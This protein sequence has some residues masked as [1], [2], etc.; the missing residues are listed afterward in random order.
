MHK[1]TKK[2]VIC[3]GTFREVLGRSRDQTGQDL[4]TFKVPWPQDLTGPKVPGLENWKSPW[5]MKTLVHSSTDCFLFFSSSSLRS[6]VIKDDTTI[7]LT[8]NAE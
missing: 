5:K 2:K 6:F 7:Q 1:C 8:C 4:E 3:P